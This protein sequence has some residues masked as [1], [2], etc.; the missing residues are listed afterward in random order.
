[1]YSIFFVRIPLGLWLY[2]NVYWPKKEKLTR[3]KTFWIGKNIIAH[4]NAHILLHTG[5]PVLTW[6]TWARAW[7]TTFKVYSDCSSRLRDT[8]W[9]IN[10]NSFPFVFFS[11]AALFPFRHFLFSLVYRNWIYYFIICS[12]LLP[13][14]FPF[15]CKGKC[16]AMCKLRVIFFAWLF[17]PNAFERAMKWW[18]VVKNEW[19]HPHSHW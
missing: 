4:Q 9:P 19:V 6:Y 10:A 2:N 18:S 17:I 11:A 7:S 5:I 13:I 8:E 3:A 15:R 14:F 1:M 16:D 12:V